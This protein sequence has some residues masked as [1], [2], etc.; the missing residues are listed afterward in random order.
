MWGLIT[1][2]ISAVFAAFYYKYNEYLDRFKIVTRLLWQFLIALC[3]TYLYFRTFQV[4]DISNLSLNSWIYIILLTITA[5]F[6][7][8]GFLML[9]VKKIGGTATGML[10]FL[11]PIFGVSLAIIIFGENLTLIQFIGWIIILITILNIKKI[12]YEHIRKDGF[13]SR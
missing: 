1:I 13:K 10:D 9:S 7:A 4:S 11:E 5:S 6:G 2:I 8:Y 12:K 3:I